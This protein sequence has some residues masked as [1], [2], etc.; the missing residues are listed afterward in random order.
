MKNPNDS[1]SMKINDSVIGH[2]FNS[3]NEPIKKIQKVTKNPHQ[4]LTRK[5]GIKFNSKK[6]K[7]SEEILNNRQRKTE[8]ESHLNIQVSKTVNFSYDKKSDSGVCRP[9]IAKYND[10][11]N[12]SYLKSA[13]D[14]NKPKKKK[15]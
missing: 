6:N 8:S 5:I 14:L 9:G 11:L 10:D 4:T 15:Y 7:E 3:K 1:L 13:T 2:A 12:G